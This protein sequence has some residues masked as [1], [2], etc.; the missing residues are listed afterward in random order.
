MPA[1]TSIERSALHDREAAR[2]LAERPRGLPVLALPGDPAQEPE[3]TGGTAVT[4]PA[5]RRRGDPEWDN[6]SVIS[7]DVVGQ[8]RTLKDEMDGGLVQYGFGEA[9]RLLLAEGLLDELKLWLHPVLSGKATPT[10]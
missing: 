7:R 6:A 10:S 4:A 3:T 1:S 2:L 5:A 9:S 8:I